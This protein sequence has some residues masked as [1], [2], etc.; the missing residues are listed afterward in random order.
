MKITAL[1]EY[2]LRCLLQLAKEEQDS[3]VTVAEIAERE[4]LSNE[5][6]SKIMTLLR[7]GGLV[8]SVRGVTGGYRLIKP[9]SEVTIADLS[10]A[11]SQPLYG[12][13]FCSAHSGLSTEC[14]H[15][16]L[17]GVRAVWQ[18]IADRVNETM[19]GITLSEVVDMHKRDLSLGAMKNE[20]RAV[21]H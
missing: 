9:S 5:Y 8:E 16:D 11:V 10:F 20:E 2:G 4:S 12:E 14:V 7:R 1:E 18:M 15:A 19:R 3:L 17:C 21:S 6:V 13:E